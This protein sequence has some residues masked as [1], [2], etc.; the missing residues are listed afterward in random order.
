V[1]SGCSQRVLGALDARHLHHHGL[2]TNDVQKAA[3]HRDP[4][5]T[6]LDNQRGYNP[7]KAASFFAI[8]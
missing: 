1:P 8:Y 4:S 5:R 3:K 7:E 6:K 2:E